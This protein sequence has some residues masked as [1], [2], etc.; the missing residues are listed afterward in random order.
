MNMLKPLAI[1]LLTKNHQDLF[2]LAYTDQLT[3]TYNRN[4]LEEFR[5]SLDSETNEAIFVTMVD[6]DG[7]KTINDTEGHAAGDAYIR[8]VAFL[9]SETTSTIFRLGG[10]EFLLLSRK[11]L[12]LMH[13]QHISYGSVE[14]L[15][16]ELLTNAM[17]RADKLMYKHKQYKKN[18]KEPVYD[19]HR[20]KNAKVGNNSE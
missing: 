12:N 14:L 7:L 8:W 16:N 13:I 20:N 2:Y 10:D 6:I 5:A 9:L 4:M 15:P 1:P 19:V 17:H 3:Q 18:R 11:P